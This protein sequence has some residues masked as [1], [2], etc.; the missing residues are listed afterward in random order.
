MSNRTNDEIYEKV[1]EIKTLLTKSQDTWV[2]KAYFDTAI[3]GLS[4]SGGGKKEEDPSVI[5]LGAAFSAAAVHQGRQQR[6]AS[7]RLTETAF[8]WHSHVAQPPRRGISRA[9]G[10]RRPRHSRQ[11]GNCRNEIGG[12]RRPLLRR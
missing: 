8:T 11:S 7:H 10:A 2:T 12:S 9:F 5:G 4:T 6:S 3:K 1:A